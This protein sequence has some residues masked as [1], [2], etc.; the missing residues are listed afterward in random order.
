MIAPYGLYEMSNGE[1]IIIGVQSNRD[2]MP[3]ATDVLG[4]PSL[5]TYPRFFDNSEQMANIDEIKVLVAG[6]FATISSAEPLNQFKRGRVTYTTVRD[7][8]ALGQHEQL[9]A[10]GRFMILTT[11]TGT[12]EVYRPPFNISGL[13]ESESS[14][15]ALVDHLL[16]RAERQQRVPDSE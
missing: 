2:W 3:F 9:R 5:G 10:R 7:P 16:T 14:V 6:T 13:G 1:Q 8:H 15:P 4:N 11:P 12:S